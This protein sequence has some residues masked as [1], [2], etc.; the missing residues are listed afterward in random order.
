MLVKKLNA[1]T[2]LMV[3]LFLISSCTGKTVE[4]ERG[5]AL[6]STGE[7]WSVFVYMCAG[8]VDTEI[9]SDT[10]YEMMKPAY[11]ENINFIVQTGGKSDWGIDG[12]Y[13]DYIQRFVMQKGSMFLASQT[14]AMDMC[15]SDTLSDFLNWGIS[16]YPA[17]N[18]ALILWG[19]G[20][21][22][23]TGM[24]YDELNGESSL[25]IEDIYYALSQTSKNFELVGFDASCMGNIET[26]S[27]IAP[28]A[29]YMLASED[30]ISPTGFDYR[31][32][33]E[34]LMENPDMSGKDLG[35]D[36]CNAYKEKAKRNGTD[37]IAMS[38][39]YDLSKMSELT[40]AFDGM[41]GMMNVS[42]DNLDYA[43][44][45]MRK[46]EYVERLG[47]LT[48][49]EGFCDM[50]DLSNLAETIQ[51]DMGATANELLRVLGEAIV[52]N[53]SNELHPYAKGMGVYF[54]VSKTDSGI[55]TNSILNYCK[56]FT[57][58]Q[59]LT[60]VRKVAIKQSSELGPGEE[61]FNSTGAYWGYTE[62]VGNMD[63]QTAISADTVSADLTA[64]MRLVR[65]V[66]ILMY[67]TDKNGRRYEIGRCYDMSG[68]VSDT[69]YQREMP[70]KCISLNG[71]NL[72]AERIQKGYTQDIYSAPIYLNG[73]YAQLRILAFK[74]EATGEITDCSLI[75]VW[76]GMTNV[77]A[78]DSRNMK[79]LS[80][81]DKIEPIYHMAETYEPIRRKS[82]RVG[83]LGSRVGLS[84][85]LGTPSCRFEVYD[86][87]GICHQGEILEN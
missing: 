41:A 80:A 20:N 14:K 29:K 74:D 1:I 77:N 70:Q 19:Q 2:A 46:L 71:H 26:A 10:L 61:D 15:A 42:L 66:D 86:I 12:V 32:M 84:K 16:S 64:D 18:Y 82:F 25:E 33:A 21:G 79:K 3:S 76:T 11:T 34:R 85:I 73:E 6:P 83:I 72:M 45:L 17:K 40:Q 87:Y 9:V 59:Y 48:Y 69:H 35:I 28:Y 22:T 38:A 52:Y 51:E 23:L 47:A 63:I 24:G 8:N 65:D 49:Y 37:N 68:E 75:G 4:L 56:S 5:K 39:V 58:H 7:S 44:S 62:T 55:I 13:P 53:V 31:H 43:V 57:S 50:A 27:A 30:I 60:F 81:F 67:A 54:P 78:V 36:M